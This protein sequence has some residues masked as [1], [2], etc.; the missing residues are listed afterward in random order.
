VLALPAEVAIVMIEHDM[1]IATR[2]AE[3]ITVLAMGQVVADGLPD[4]V[5]ANPLVRSS[6]LG[7]Q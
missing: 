4:E 5:R 7:E 3:R 1:S 6:Y 2:F